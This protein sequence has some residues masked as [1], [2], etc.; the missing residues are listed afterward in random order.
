MEPVDSKLYYYCI[1]LII[2]N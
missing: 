1:V 2:C